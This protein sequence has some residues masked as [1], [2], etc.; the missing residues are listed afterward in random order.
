MEREMRVWNMRV[1]MCGER[2]KG[3]KERERRQIAGEKFQQRRSFFDNHNMQYKIEY[4]EQSSENH[5]S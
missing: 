3:E 4:T 5:L 2:M 1:R